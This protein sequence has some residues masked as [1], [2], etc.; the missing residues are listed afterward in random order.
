M[1]QEAVRNR[2]YSRFSLPAALSNI[3]YAHGRESL[4]VSLSFPVTFATFVL[5]DNDLGQTPL[6]D[7]SGLN[8]DAFHKRPANLQ[9][10]SI[11]KEKHLIKSDVFPDLA[12]NLFYF[13]YMPGA[14]FVLSPAGPEDGVHRFKSSWPA[15]KNLSRSKPAP[16]I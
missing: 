2:F 6:L 15:S 9:L 5:E 10:I 12:G 7:D 11:G 14:G 13:D 1:E 4:P 8:L 3:F 16:Q